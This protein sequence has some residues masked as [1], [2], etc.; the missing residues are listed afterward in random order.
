M[1]TRMSNGVKETPKSPTIRNREVSI[2]TQSLRYNVEYLV[3][4]CIEFRELQTKCRE[5]SIYF[6]CIHLSIYS[7]ATHDLNLV[8]VP[9]H[10]CAHEFGSRHLL[11]FVCGLLAAGVS[12]Q[13]LPGWCRLWSRLA[14]FI[15]YVHIFILQLPHKAANHTMQYCNSM[16]S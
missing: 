6:K 7:I 12:S 11:N 15:N 9:M 14:S 4:L 10:A 3:I 13:F 8:C 16:D 2:G 1:Q 5:Y